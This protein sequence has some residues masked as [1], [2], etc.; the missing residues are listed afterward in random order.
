MDSSLPNFLKLFI[1]ALEEKIQENEMIA[2]KITNRRNNTSAKI[3]GDFV[4]LIDEAEIIYLVDVKADTTKISKEYAHSH[5]KKLLERLHTDIGAYALGM[6]FMVLEHEIEHI[7][8]C[9]FCEHEH[10]SDLKVV[11]IDSNVEYYLSSDAA[12]IL[13]KDEIKETLSKL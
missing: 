3:K 12:V 9:P 13:D 4:K 5:R 7:Y 10:K 6:R 1:Q 8:K 2:S 11:D